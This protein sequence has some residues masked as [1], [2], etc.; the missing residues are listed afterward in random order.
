M[1][2]VGRHT[3]MSYVKY[4]RVSFTDYFRS[5]FGNEYCE[6][7]LSTLSFEMPHIFILTLVYFNVY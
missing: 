6:N 2:L 5:K 7:I 3:S 4:I 1:L